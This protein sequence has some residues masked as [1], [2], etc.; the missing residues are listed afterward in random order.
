MVWCFYSRAFVFSTFRWVVLTLL[1]TAGSARAAPPKFS[2]GGFIFSAQYGPGFWNVNQAALAAQVGE[3][4]ASVF[5][6]DLQTSH[7]LSLKAAYVILGH[8]SVGVDFTATGWD[9]LSSNRGGAGFIVGTVAWHPLESVFKILK[10]EKR[11]VNFD[12]SSGIGLGYGIA[13]ERLGS[14]GFTVEWTIDFDWFFTRWFALGTFARGAF[15]KWNALYLDFDH[16]DVPGNTLPLPNGLGGAFWTVGLSLN[17][18]A[19]E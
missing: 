13:G 17:F 6:G 12:L 7:T 3:S 8:A 19:G 10:Y 16:R 18:R 14:D 5:V 1:V 15:L 11:P 2:E 4:F 9:V